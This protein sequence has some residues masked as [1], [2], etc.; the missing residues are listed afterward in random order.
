MCV[1]VCL[2]VWQLHYHHDF[3]ALAAK[4]HGLKLAPDVELS[5]NIG[6]QKLHVGGSVLCN[7]Q[8]RMIGMAKVGELQV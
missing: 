4:V 3:V 5:A 8:S 7:T 6:S 2:C 1:C